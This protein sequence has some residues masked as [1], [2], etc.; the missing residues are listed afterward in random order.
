MGIIVLLRLFI[1]ITNLRHILQTQNLMFLLHVIVFS[2]TYVLRCK[3]LLIRKLFILWKK[4]FKYNLNTKNSLS[5]CLLRLGILRVLVLFCILVLY[6]PF[7][8]GVLKLDIS[9][10]FT[11]FC[12]WTSLQF[13]L[14]ICVRCYIRLKQEWKFWIKIQ[15]CLSVNTVLW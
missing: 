13:K 15:Y 3:G 11:T 14:F 5:E 6:G 8:H 1:N 2:Q 12:L 7:C 10:L 9:T 4:D